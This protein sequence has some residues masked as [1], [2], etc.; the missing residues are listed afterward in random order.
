[1]VLGALCHNPD[2]VQKRDFDILVV[3]DEE[4]NLD[5]AVQTLGG[6]KL[7]VILLTLLANRALSSAVF[8][9]TLSSYC[10]F[11]LLFESESVLFRSSSPS[12]TFSNKD[13]SNKISQSFLF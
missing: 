5:G 4:E 13:F 2:S 9:G 12:F 6:R 1:M 11:P 8:H 10:A 3:E 7:R